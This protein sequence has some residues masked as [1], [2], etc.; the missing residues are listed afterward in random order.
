MQ[1]QYLVNLVGDGLERLQ[2]IS[3]LTR[4]ASLHNTYTLMQYGNSNDSANLISRVVSKPA[5]NSWTFALSMQHSKTRYT[6]VHYVSHASCL[7]SHEDANKLSCS[8]FTFQAI[9]KPFS[10]NPNNSVAA[11]NNAWEQPLLSAFFSVFTTIMEHVFSIEPNVINS[12]QFS[13]TYTSTRTSFRRQSMLASKLQQK[14][15]G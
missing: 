6:H 10:L 13:P 5:A 3:G 15:C 7:V 9:L 4:C 8:Q 12:Q 1:K 2:Y 14:C 11:V